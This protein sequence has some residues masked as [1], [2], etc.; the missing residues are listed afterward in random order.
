MIKD[1]R[2]QAEKAERLAKSIND[3]R[4]CEALLNYARECRE[5]LEAVGTTGD[6]YAAPRSGAEPQT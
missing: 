6:N 2:D 3:A 4:T 5:K 1:F